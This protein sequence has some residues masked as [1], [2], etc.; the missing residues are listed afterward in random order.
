[1]NKELKD[2]A[3]IE[4]ILKVLKDKG[5]PIF[6]NDKFNYNLNT[7][8][9]R[10]SNLSSNMFNDIEV[11]FWKYKGVMYVEY[12]AIT[13]DPGLTY[14]IKPINNKGT[15]ILL[16][17]HVKGGFK[18]GKHKGYEALVQATPFYGL[19]DND[20]DGDISIL[21]LYSPTDILT[22]FNVK[23]VGDDKLIF[24]S[25]W[26]RIGRL[27]RGVFGINNHRASKWKIL[28]YIG[29]YSAGCQVHQS[30]YEYRNRFLPLYREASIL[31]G[32]SFSFSL[33]TEIDL[34]KVI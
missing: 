25:A 4:N 12:F 14:R 28:E 29:L 23:R 34:D 5:Y 31:Y 10:S 20:K 22:N 18:L 33:I 15:F 24:D 26:N 32:N 19:R 30:P 11:V 7:V 8:L 6:L 1:M 13:T 9:I 17:Q 16:P 27:V 3:V 21:S 2:K